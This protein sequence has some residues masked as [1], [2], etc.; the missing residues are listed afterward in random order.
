MRQNS[1]SI[2]EQHTDPFLF[3]LGV[4]S[5]KELPDAA[6]AASISALPALRRFS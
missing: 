3:Q 2:Q 4:K 6:G 5:I 1:V